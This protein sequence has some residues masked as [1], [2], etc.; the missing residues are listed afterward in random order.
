MGKRANH[1]QVLD[2]G[3]KRHGRVEL[4]LLQLK[5]QQRDSRC[6]ITGDRRVARRSTTRDRTVDRGIE[7]R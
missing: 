5:Q 3:V 1:P 4:D 7:G 6:G 2:L